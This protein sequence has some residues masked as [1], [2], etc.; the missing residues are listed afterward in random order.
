[1][2]KE[3][4]HEASSPPE[5]AD[6]MS[7]DKRK[8]LQQCFEKANEL[9]N[10][11]KPDRDYA[12]DLYSQVVN[13]DPGNLVYVEA[14]LANLQKKYNNNKRGSRF[15]FGGRKAFKEAVAEEDWKEIFRE[16]L[17]LL[18][19]NPW[20]TQV[21]RELA[22][23]CA[24]NR[25]NEVELRYLKNALDGKPKDVDVNRHCAQSL[26]RVG[27]FDMAIA[28]WNRIAEKTKSSEAEKMMSEL[29]LAKTMG[30]PASI[31]AIGA[32]GDR[33]MSPKPLTAPVDPDAKEPDGKR[34]TSP[35]L[36]SEASV[37]DDDED[38]ASQR[39]RGSGSSIKLNQRQLLEKSIREEPTNSIAY[40]QLA[41]LH[42]KERRFVEAERV[43]AEA[44]AAVGPSLALETEHENAQI[45]S[46]RA[47]VAIAEQRA[48]GATTGEAAELVA[49]LKSDLNRLELGIFQKRS[50]RYPDQLRLHYELGLRL[51]RAG[52]YLEAI[53]SYDEARKDSDCLVSATLEMGECW[54][55][56]KQYAKAMK[57][58]QVAIN[59]ST[60]L[61][62]DRQKLALYRGAVLATALKNTDQAKLW[63]EQLVELDAN[64]KDAA[65]RLDKLV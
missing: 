21:L 15:S 50:Q 14:M 19:N 5:Q 52:N 4:A 55:Q 8:R 49:K 26:A 16:G 60:E 13:S 47:R 3:S 39:R 57:C 59:E 36:A 41:E 25:Y 45:K 1:M 12:H 62:G 17:E 44:I 32:T 35:S 7:P 51:R 65:A 27:Q 61:D 63:L 53:K 42:S 6:V 38:G 9:A 40:L 30:M 18:K 48:G 54:Q 64:F 10:K 31:E 37:I 11:A 20:D 23:A 2:A 28:C 22:R 43:L 29:T 33:P 34:K 56:L 58:Y 46:F 24:F